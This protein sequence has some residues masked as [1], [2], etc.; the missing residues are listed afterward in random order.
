MRRYEN[1]KSKTT[2]VKR[3]T[4]NLSYNISS[5]N[6]IIYSS[7]PKNDN[8]IYVISQ[9]GDRLDLLANQ[10][11]GDPTLWWYIARANNLKFITLEPGTSIRIP[12]STSYA[13]GV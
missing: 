11:Y 1:N 12:S 8:D 4:K 13:T 10:F 3:G 2:F 9:A 7:I 6:T 5:F